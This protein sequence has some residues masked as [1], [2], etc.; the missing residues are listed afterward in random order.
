[1]EIEDRKHITKDGNTVIILQPKVRLD[2]STSWQLKMKLQECISQIS[3]YVIVNLAQVTFIDSAGLSSL[4]AGKRI[5]QQFKGRFCICSLLPTA[6][7]IFEV[8]MMDTMLEIF[9]TEEEA[10]KKFLPAYL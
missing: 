8:T 9:D 4:V 5:V 2:I 1:M 6:K 7:L 10:L 3:C